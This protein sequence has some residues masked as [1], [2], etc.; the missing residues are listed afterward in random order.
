M[1]VSM[2][3]LRWQLLDNYN[4][5][6]KKLNRSIKKYET[7][8]DKITLSPEDIKKEMSSI[9]LKDSK[10]G[11]SKILNPSSLSSYMWAS[12]T[13]QLLMLSEDLD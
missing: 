10:C 11:L 5:L 13:M 7:F 9:S 2:D 6:T 1:T 4:S 12:I 3:V 8:D